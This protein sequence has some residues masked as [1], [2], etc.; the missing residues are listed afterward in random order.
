MKPISRILVAVK[1]TRRKSCPEVA[2]AA[3]LARALGARLELFH[4]LC[5]PVT[6]DALTGQALEKFQ[7][8]E[9]LRH[10]KRLEAMAVALRRQRI[11]VTTA[12]EWDYPSHEALIRRA[13]LMRADLIVA[14]RHASRHV[15][16]W[17]LRY[18]DWELLRESPVPVLLVKK[19]RPYAHPGILAAVDPSHA[20][21]RTA[22]LDQRILQLGDGIR[23]ATRGALHVLHAYTP[24]IL[25]MGELELAVSNATQRIADKSAKL[26]QARLDKA[27]VSAGVGSLAADRRHVVPLHPIDSIPR[28]A[29]KLR[30]DIVVM[31]ALS[32]SGFSGLVIGN[33]AE[34]LLDELPCDLL[35]VKPPGFKTRV[36]TRARGP[37]LTFAAPPSALT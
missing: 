36:S 28:L 6:F 14:G 34:R 11:D 21:A 20:L 33:T 27:L 17:F 23:A 37:E 32:R 35:V 1:N 31:G 13:R 18:T 30:C 25:G 16:P 7:L 10:R 26:A 5:G 4:A 24:G 8:A 15:A 12:V 29:R 9:R 19:P 3:A 2:K 22:Q